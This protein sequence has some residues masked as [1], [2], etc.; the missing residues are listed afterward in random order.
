M[1]T[2]VTSAQTWR[3]PPVEVVHRSRYVEVDGMRTHYLEAG[4]GPAVVLFHSGEFGGVPRRA[5]NISYPR[6]PAISG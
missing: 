3:V 1:N 6:S 5:G 2:V 4:E